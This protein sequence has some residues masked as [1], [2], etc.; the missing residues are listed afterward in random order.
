MNRCPEHIKGARIGFI[1]PG[2]PFFGHSDHT[3][4]KQVI[5]HG[6]VEGLERGFVSVVSV[7]PLQQGGGIFALGGDEQLVAAYV[8]ELGVVLGI[9]L[10]V[11]ASQSRNHF[12]VGS[13][14]AHGRACPHHGRS[15]LVHSENAL[16]TDGKAT[17]HGWAYCPDTR[18]VE[19]I[20]PDAPPVSCGDVNW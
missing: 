5:G 12:V 10:A 6:A 14:A 8:Q 1:R 20:S 7:S 4:R 16:F 15:G 11:G 2:L 13:C 3:P 17:V 9:A 19:P 18:A